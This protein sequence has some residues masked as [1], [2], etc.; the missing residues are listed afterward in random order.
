MTAKT[1]YNLKDVEKSFVK[2]KEKITVFDK[3]NMA[4]PEGDFLAI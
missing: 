4:I 3:L 1:L 2:G